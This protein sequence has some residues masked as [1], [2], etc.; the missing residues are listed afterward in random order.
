MIFSRTLFNRRIG[1]FCRKLWG[2][3]AKH[4][5]YLLLLLFLAVA[6]FLFG[7][8]KIL[9]SMQFVLS[10][11]AFFRN[12]LSTPSCAKHLENAD[13]YHKENKNRL[14]SLHPEIM[15]IHI[16]IFLL[17]AFFFDRKEVCI[18]YIYI[19]PV[20]ITNQ[21]L[22]SGVKQELSQHPVWP[23]GCERCWC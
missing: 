21:R 3:E 11:F 15:T 9:R 23:E 19:A 7:C 22:S 18:T 16:L 10:W 1:G 6:G 12:F 5:V 8:K 13:K 17:L 4:G 14:S 20:L 2:A